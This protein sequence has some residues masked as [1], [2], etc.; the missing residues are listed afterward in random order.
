[1]RSLV[2][3]RPVGWFGQSSALCV[4]LSF[5]SPLSVTSLLVATVSMRLVPLGVSVWLRCRV[6][7]W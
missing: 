2:S 3:K 5:V 7:S 4:L 1:L 6:F